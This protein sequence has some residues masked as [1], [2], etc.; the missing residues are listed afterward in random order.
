[1]AR[2]HQRPDR[3]LA[4]VV[5]V[6]RRF[7]RR[8]VVVVSRDLNLQNKAKFPRIPYMEPPDPAGPTA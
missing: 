6:M 3:I 1:V 8:P 5:E 4:S 7:P 2:Q